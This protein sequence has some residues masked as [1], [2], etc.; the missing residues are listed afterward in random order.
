MA[1]IRPQLGRCTRAANAGL[2]EEETTGAMG[3]EAS[4]R[5]G[6]PNYLPSQLLGGKHPIAA[7]NKFPYLPWTTCVLPRDR[8]SPAVCPAYSRHPSNK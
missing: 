6:L 5:S 2:G 1:S 7:K 4:E 8:L 3:G